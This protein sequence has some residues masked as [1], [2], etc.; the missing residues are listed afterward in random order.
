MTQLDQCLALPGGE[1]LAPSIEHMRVAAYC[2]YGRPEEEC[3]QVLENYLDIQPELA[4]RAIAI[5]A[6]CGDR[7]ELAPRYLTR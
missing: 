2:S 6:A 3:V 5:L 1:E 7:P 4:P